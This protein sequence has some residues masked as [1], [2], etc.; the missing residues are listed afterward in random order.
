MYDLIVFIGRFQPFSEHHKEIVRRARAQADNVLILVGSANSRRTTRNP[1]TYLERSS[2]I[3]EFLDIE[4]IGNVWIAALQD[5]TYNDNAWAL[6]VNKE[7]SSTCR[8]IFAN[9]RWS[10]AGTLDYKI[11]II[12][13]KKDETTTH[14]EMFPQYDVIDVGYINAPS[15]SE[16]R[17][18]IFS[19]EDEVE[20]VP[21]IQKELHVPYTVA[22]KLASMY[23]DELNYRS[24]WGEGPFLTADSVVR[25]GDHVLLVERSDGGGWAL[26][27]GF[28]NKN[29][30]FFQAAIRELREETR[31][32]VPERVLKGSLNKDKPRRV[33]DDPNR[34]TRARIVTEAF[35]FDLVHDTS[36][37]EVRGSD[38]A[39][40]AFWCPIIDLK[41]EMF[42]DDHYHILTYFLG[43]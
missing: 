18:K 23:F 20:A 42:F 8:S 27:G 24:E 30:T 33:F 19:A 37:P 36:L 13:H 6:S 31:L 41:E 21:V 15:A 32:R 22:K 28:L 5:K 1:L 29:E 17:E 10:P 34:S 2:M 3:E 4:D 14:L 35:Y 12:G 38:D 16:I 26:P 25:V 43:I 9:N 11:G 39:K 7:I 40:R